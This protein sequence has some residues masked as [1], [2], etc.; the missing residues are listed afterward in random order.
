MSLSKLF[1]EPCYM[2]IIQDFYGSHKALLAVVSRL[3][4]N[5][6]KKKYGCKTSVKYCAKSLQL[7]KLAISADAANI[8]KYT[9]HKLTNYIAS[10][11]DIDSLKYALDNKCECDMTASSIAAQNGHIDLVLW[12]LNAGYYITPNVCAFAARG[13]HLDFIKTIFKNKD[14][15]I[16]R[17]FT[18]AE[19]QYIDFRF[20]SGIPTLAAENGHFDI[21]IWAKE[22]DIPL[23][24]NDGNT[25]SSAAKGGH[26]DIL[27]YAYNNGCLL[28]K[29]VPIF[30]AR[31]G[32]LH[33]LKWAR[34]N[35][36]PWTDEF[37]SEA[38][39]NGHLDILI[40]AKDNN[41]WKHVWTDT[42]NIHNI[43]DSA[44]EGGHINVLLWI[45]ENGGIFDK[46]TCSSAASYEHLDTLKWLR[47]RGCDWDEDTCSAAARG[48]SL[49]ILI[50]ARENGCPWD[51][52]TI[53]EAAAS[54]NKEIVEWA[55]LNGCPQPS[56]EAINEAMRNYY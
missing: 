16:R 29:Y 42:Y 23:G 18:Y 3:W 53:L 47:N 40:W 20:D 52:D 15:K 55:K 56:Q 33:I 5:S 39:R 14:K 48:G 51:D 35:N 43:C 7:V 13:G 32:H 2:D 26:L 37:L 22:N 27:I 10:C 50:W 28:D 6:Y 46:D 21:V 34:K 41:L 44:A 25:C 45:E 54:E 31:H 1:V 8:N 30:A 4:Y 11:G 9:V 19:D 12:A 38:A 17:K 36:C 24:S 49:D